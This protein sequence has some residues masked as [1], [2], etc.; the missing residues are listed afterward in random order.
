MS[1]KLNHYYSINPVM[2][3]EYEKFIINKF[4]PG[5][6]SLDLH[7]VAVWSVL[8]GAYSEIVFENASSDLELI[9]KALRDKRYKDLKRDLFKYVKNY[10]TKVLVNTG[11]IDSYSI[12]ILK[13][14]IKFSQ[15]W[16]IQSHKK[17]EYE[18]FIINEYFPVLKELGI[19]VAGE[20]EVLIGDGP[21]IICEGRVSDINNLINNLQSKKFQNAKRKLREHIE[22][23]S[24]RILTFHIHKVKGYKSASYQMV[25]PV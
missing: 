24:S 11:K 6:N 2:N 1:V 19:S 10:K 18:Q 3:E 7:T 21:G 15:M 14:T 9:E 4:I 17:D 5:V 20:W 16:D 23:Y 8:I 22:N 12:D 13:D 25:K